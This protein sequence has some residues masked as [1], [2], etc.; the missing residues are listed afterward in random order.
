MTENSKS[1]SVDSL[2][3]EIE[4]LL[5]HTYT[6]SDRAT[7]YAKKAVNS[8]LQTAHESD[9]DRAMARRS[10]IAVLS[11]T[12]DGCPYQNL[13][14]I[15]SS[16]EAQAKVDRDCKPADI[17]NLG[18]TAVSAVARPRMLPAVAII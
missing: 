16:I 3:P 5:E 12:L 15:Q 13:E 10:V 6:A 18:S 11:G 8:W 9:Y 14:C 4:P 1:L 7:T 17:I 2:Y